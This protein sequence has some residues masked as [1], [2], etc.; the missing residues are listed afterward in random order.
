M[1]TAT[2]ESAVCE[3]PRLSLTDGM[4]RVHAVSWAVLKGLLRC[5]YRN[6]KT[7]Y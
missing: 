2:E 4:Q 6:N 7:V 1:D 3:E 5:K